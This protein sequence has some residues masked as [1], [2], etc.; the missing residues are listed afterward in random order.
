MANSDK[1][2]IITP[3][4]G[5]I[6]QP[7]IRFVG[8]GNDPITLRV[9]DGVT[10]TGATAGAALSVEG[11]AGQ[12]F[13]IVNRLGTGSI[14]SVNDISGIPLVDANANG[15]ISLA[16]YFGNVGIGYTSPSDSYKFSVNGNAFIAGASGTVV[17]GLVTAQAGI[18]AAGGVTFSGTIASD[19]GYR[20]TS[21]AINAQT[22]TT[23]T[24]LDGDNGKVVTFNNGSAVTV[25][26]PT[27]LPVGFNCT[28][29][30]LGAGQVGFTAASGVTLQSY[31]SQYRL[32]GQHASASIIEYSANIVNLS[33]NLVV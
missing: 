30:Q 28:A 32:I 16:G 19:T 33:G 17:A 29:I 4:V 15:N 8:Q 11:S 12:L 10:G 5:G 2:I 27:G 20:I 21:N 7:Q 6:T 22:G 26:I 25:T 23:Y 31:G 18:S 3:F 14:F 24:F 1:N 13:S 9:L